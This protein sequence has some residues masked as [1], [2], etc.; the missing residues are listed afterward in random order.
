LL[1]AGTLVI[2]A[3]IVSLQRQYA[4]RA[5]AR[6]DFRTVSHYVE[7]HAEAGD[8]VVLVGGHSYPAFAYYF[9]GDLAV[10]PMPP[11]LLPSTRDPLD[12]RAVA[13]LAEIAAGRER[14]WLV[15]W[16]DRLADPTGVVLNYLLHTCPR[17]GVHKKFHG[18]ALLLFSVADCDLTTRTGPSHPLRAEF[19]GQMRLLGYDLAPAAAMPGTILHLTLYWEAMGEVAANYTTFV[20]LLGPDGYIYAQHDR[21]TGDDA[22]P[23]SHWQPGA[24]IFNPH[25]LTV[26]PGTPPGNYRLIAGLYVADRNLP[27]LPITYPPGTIDD[28]VVLG[29]IKVEK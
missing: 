12:Y 26:S 2:G 9:E 22:Y 16:Q 25:T 13:Q 14:L 29:E 27:R 6:P 19:G 21:L 3:S 23:T 20:Q 15:L 4:D 1:L 28:A 7:Q 18:L 17:L 5:L 11:D 8:V 10:H 24:V